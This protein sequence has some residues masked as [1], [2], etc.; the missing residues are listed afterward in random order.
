MKIFFRSLVLSSLLLIN[1]SAHEKISGNIKLGHTFDGKDNGYD[2]TTGS[3]YYLNLAYQTATYNGFDA[4]ISASIVGD[5]GLT[6]KNKRI[7]KGAFMGENIGDHILDT[8]YQI[9]EAYIKYKKGKTKF[10]AGHFRLNTPMTHNAT[11]T[12]P[13]LYEGLIFSSREILDKSIVIGGFIPRMAYGARAL[14]DWSR[15]GEKTG[16]AG[17]VKVYSVDDDPTPDVTELSL[18][19]NGI[20]RGKWTNMGKITGS[21]DNSYLFLGGI[22][23]KSLPNTTIQAWEYFTNDLVNI[24]YID[25]MKKEELSNGIKTMIGAQFMLQKVKNESGTPML[26]GLKGALSYQELKFIAAYNKSN[27]DKIFNLWGG[28][29]AFTSS[30]ISKNAYRPD[31]DAYKFIAQYKVPTF[32]G[33]LPKGISL[34][35]SH[36]IYSKSS[37]PNTQKDASETDTKLKYM[38]NKDL[39]FMLVNVQRTTEFD[40]YEGKDKTQNTSKFVIKYRF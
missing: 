18:P 8:K 36:A 26:F 6:D 12:V 1:A 4:K 13:N 40:G 5:T 34:M 29:P 37:L 31:V 27:S 28:D 16:T 33:K 21:D 3:F 2:T 35:V 19:Q 22:L 38:P 20:R 14:S 10:K 30:S 25:A 17:S 39:M 7:T 32:N 11:S 9:E 23:N 15:I 24:F